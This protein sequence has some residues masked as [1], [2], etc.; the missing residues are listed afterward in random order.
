[1]L[2]GEGKSGGGGLE[3]PAEP[4]TFLYPTRDVFPQEFWVSK[5]D[6]HD[7]S[8]DLRYCPTD[9]SKNRVN[10]Y[11]KFGTRLVDISSLQV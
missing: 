4:V 1:M 3:T 10:Q 6:C 9:T 8:T 7:P 11:V 5:T 2:G